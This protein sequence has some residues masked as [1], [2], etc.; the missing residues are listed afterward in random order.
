MT[1]QGLGREDLKVAN[2]AIGCRK[3]RKYQGEPNASYMAYILG[4]LGVSK[5]DFGTSWAR[6]RQKKETG[7]RDGKVEWLETIWNL[8]RSGGM[9]TS[10]RW[11]KNTFVIYKAVLY[12]YVD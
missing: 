10:S 3:L 6:A 4:F 1:G 12:L 5:S 8:L 7:G 11:K 2:V 9:K